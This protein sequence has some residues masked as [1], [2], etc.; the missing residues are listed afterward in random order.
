MTNS[1][2]SSAISLFKEIVHDLKSSKKLS[3]IFPSAL[4]F[5]K[6]L[7]DKDLEKWLQL[8]MNGYIRPNPALTADVVV[9]E[10]RTVPGQ[11]YDIYGRPL[12]LSDPKMSFVNEYRLRHGV[13][14][15]EKFA[16]YKDF[17]AIQDSHFIDGIKKHLKVNVYSFKFSPDA[18]LGILDAIKTNLINKIIAIK[19]DFILE[20]QM[21]DK[22]ESKTFNIAFSNL[23]P[24]IIKVANRLFLDGHYRQAILDTYIFLVDEVRKISGR[25]DLD[26]TS[27][28][29]KVFSQK[30]P[31]IKL[32]DDPDEQL[33]F[34]WLFKGAVMGI[35]NPKAHKLIQLKDPQKALEW[36]SFASVLL[37]ILDE[38]EV[39]KN[40]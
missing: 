7:K 15:L 10:Y 32:S 29:E 16:E 39:L 25:I 3:E 17:I 20:E 13:V 27:L 18:I 22:P 9:P 21:K 12:V 35:R 4:I 14:E 24:S 6:E 8:E 37:R 36:L 31:I 33:G 28:I 38:A 30:K 1:V 26:G 23:H 40:D 2:S 19:Q 34:M 11:Y 5:S